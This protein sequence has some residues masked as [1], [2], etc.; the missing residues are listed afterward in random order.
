MG[1]FGAALLTLLALAPIREAR[2]LAVRISP[3]RPRPGD[4]LL[5]EASGVKNPS[6]ARC[7]LGSRA[8][9]FYPL[10]PDRLRALIGITA[11]ARPG[12][13]TLLVI[14]KRLMAPDETATLPITVASRDF[15]HQSLRMS[16]ERERL[17][18]A[19]ETQAAFRLV[20][21]ALNIESKTQL[22]T[23]LFALPVE[24]RVSSLYGHSRTVNRKR[25]WSW[26]RGIDIAAPAGRPVL[27]PNRGR[28][29]LAGFY[30]LQGGAVVLDHGQG[31]V[32]VYLHLKRVACWPGDMVEKGE[33]IAA[34]GT[35]GFSTGSHL[36]SGLYVHGDPVDPLAWLTR[37][38]GAGTDVR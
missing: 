38:W 25:H 29:V 22:W 36:H 37:D 14:R 20:H 35:T 10:G 33:M 17:T 4:V 32:S 7:L 2:A 9:P 13:K 18:S 11:V 12:A 19:P 23:G 21:A 1:F 6:R 5:V 28:V 15:T 31:V 8:Y 3:D 26:H 16:K 30:P 34:V 27:A 24:G